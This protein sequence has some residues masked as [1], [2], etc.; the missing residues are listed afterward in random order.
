MKRC[1]IEGPMKRLL[2]VLFL[3]MCTVTHGEEL[4]VQSF[5]KKTSESQLIKMKQDDFNHEFGQAT[6][7]ISQLVNT[8][9]KSS[10]KLSK[11]FQLEEIEVSF[12]I[13]SGGGFILASAEVEG[14]VT[15]V[16]TKKEKR[17]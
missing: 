5:N 9:L 8:T 15:L 7:Q 11:K 1:H 2:I 12:A 6:S 14:V 10:E 4:L 17:E 16:F 13:S 3:I